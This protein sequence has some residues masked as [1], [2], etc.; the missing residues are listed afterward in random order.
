MRVVDY[1]TGAKK[2]S[3][4]DVYYGLNLQLLVYLMAVENYY[5]TRGREALPAGGFYFEIKL[6]Y[7]GEGVGEESRLSKFQMNGFILAEPAAAASLQGEAKSMNIRLQ[8]DGAELAE[9]ENTFSSQQMEELFGYTKRMILQAAAQM[10]EGELSLRP[11]GEGENLPC[12]YCDYHAVCG[13]DMLYEGNEVRQKE[14]ID[15]ARF[16]REIG[17]EH[18]LSAD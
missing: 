14:K 18:E 12:R 9:G 1:K 11:V 10:S 4:T 8:A 17:G 13:F 6:P 15:K 7:I 5:R 2:F 16:F 3:L